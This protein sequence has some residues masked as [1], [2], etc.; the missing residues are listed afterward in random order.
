MPTTNYGWDLPVIGGDDDTWG[1]KLNTAFDEADADL[2]AVSD[3]VVAAAANDAVTNAKLAN[4]ATATFKGRAT[5]GTGDP[6]DLTA[7]QAAGLLNLALI[8]STGATLASSSVDMK[9]GGL[10]VA[11]GR[12]AGGSSNPTISFAT[13]FGATPVVVPV[14]EDTHA[15]GGSGGIRSVRLQ[16]GSVGTGS[17]NAFCSFEDGTSDVFNPASDVPFTWI[18]VG[19]A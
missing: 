9:L 5:A 14:A 2:K 1:D 8:N 19:K 18:A 17:F 4:V 15:G 13:A 6:E 11:A 7:A 10:R 16:Q 12:Y 3:A